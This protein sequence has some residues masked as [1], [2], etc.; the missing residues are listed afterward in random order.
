M[1]FEFHGCRAWSISLLTCEFS[2]NDNEGEITLYVIGEGSNLSCHLQ[3]LSST[4]PLPILY[5]EPI[6][7]TFVALTM[8]QTPPNPQPPLS[9][10]WTIQIASQEHWNH[11]VIEGDAKCCLDPLFL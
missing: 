4:H 6:I 1:R 9:L 11:I 5:L 7:M 10:F 3:S 2:G 8:R